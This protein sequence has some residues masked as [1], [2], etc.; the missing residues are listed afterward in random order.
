MMGTMAVG[1][2]TAPG[3]ST[4]ARAAS[5]AVHGSFRLSELFEDLGAAAAIAHL[6][7]AEQQ[8]F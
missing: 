3:A 1:S 5:Q 2:A 4:H 7:A 8:T 6:V